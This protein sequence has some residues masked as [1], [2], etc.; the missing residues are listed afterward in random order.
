M[1]AVIAFGGLGLTLVL[2][3]TR[4]RVRGVPLGPALG[5]LPAVVLLL[6]TGVLHAGDVARAAGVLWR[7]LVTVASIMATTSV[8]H[9]LG[10]FDRVA[11]AIEIRS[12][13]AVIHAFRTVWIIG[14]TTAAVFNNDAAILLLTPIVVPLVQ[15]LYP[16]R[17][18]LA[19]PFAFAVFLSAG[20]AP[21][22]TSNPMNLVVAEHAGIGFNAYALRMVPVALIGS[23]VSYAMARLLFHRDLVDRIPARG[24]ELGSL[25]PME[26]TPSRVLWVVAGVFLAYPVLSYVDAPVWIAA[27]GGAVL[28]VMLALHGRRITPVHVVRGVAWDVLAF[29]FLVF[30]TAVGLENVGIVRVLASVYALGQGHPLGEIALVGVVS[31]GGSAIINN[32]PMAAMNALAVASLPGDATWRTLAA[33]V[34]GDLGPRLLPMGSLA[35]L[36]WVD[37]TRK[38][39]VD[40]RPGRFVVLGLVVTVPTLAASA[41]ALWIERLLS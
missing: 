20:V 14:A 24:P 41:I 15:R 39:D 3:L 28:V 17:Q 11:R 36:L 27:L 5:A 38:L 26:E 34:G 37:M 40:V 33:L 23:V 8:A 6:A 12:R 9:H 29:L 22:C 2:V 13:G 19:V 31:A 32:H 25:A 10:L 30:L 16:R 7:P 35:G 1:Q 21:L 4:P 18:Y